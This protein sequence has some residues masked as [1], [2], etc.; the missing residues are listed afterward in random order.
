LTTGEPPGAQP[1]VRGGGLFR[2]TAAVSGMTF[3]SRISGL[4]R[5]VIFARTIGTDLVADAFFVAFRIP[6]FLRRVF[7][8]GAFAVAFV[9]VFAE[10]RQK[11]PREQVQFFLDVMT[12]RL[13]LILISITLLG[14]VGAPLLVM[15]I[16]PGF[17][18]DAEKF[19]ATVDAL[20]ITF[21]Y[22]F[23]ISLVAMAGGILNTVGRFAIPAATPILLN[24][25]LIG[26]ALMLVPMMGNAAV[27]LAVGVLVAGA[28]Q[29]AF[30][31]P[32]LA[33]EGL[34]PRPRL[35]PRNEYVHR[36]FMLMLPALFGVSV[37]Q[38]NLLINTQLASFLVTGSVSWLYYA[39]RLMEFPVGVFGIA[40]AT[41]ILPSLSRMH[42]DESPEKF[43]RLL[44]W[45][46]R[47]VALITVPAAVALIVLAQPLLATLF[48]Y[49]AFGP[50]DVVMAGNALVA[51][52]VG[53]V[54][55]VL[56]K[57][58]APGF[59]AR[60]N[61]KTPV[62]IGVIAMVVNIVLAVILVFP[63]AHT[64]LALA[65]SLAAIVN[66]GLLYLKLRQEAVYLP[67]A[68]WLRFALQ[69]AAASVAMGAL[70]W[71]LSG[72]LQAWLDATLWRRIGWL[73]VLVVAGAVVYAGVILA[74]GVRP[75]QLMPPAQ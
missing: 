33:R 50:N 51:F 9:P 63:L 19:T 74:A 66:A 62:R 46:L 32:F 6:N 16:A 43:S 4:V 69:V 24:L 3:L 10:L 15:G 71:W 14:V 56:I 41:V 39:D 65:T 20:R 57:V 42:A 35:G 12:G 55:F 31:A 70:L 17:I 36:V 60:Q 44:D 18:G 5:D 11:Q 40:L 22:L 23:F 28:V 26:A 64:G 38:I 53:L 48:Q 52:S 68:G 49:G 27:A 72:D 25:C 7:G 1:P 59:Y 29:L 67:G 73:T 13:G 2:S 8:E 34:F 21:P 75:R 54:P 37:A 58:L 45:S 61:T 30:Q 47:W